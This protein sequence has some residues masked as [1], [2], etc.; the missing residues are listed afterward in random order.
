[1]ITKFKDI[2]VGAGLKFNKDIL[3]DAD[4]AKWKAM[5]DTSSQN[6]VWA[7]LLKSS[8]QYM[9]N[10][11]V[12]KFF[13]DP[14]ADFG[15]AYDYRAFIAKEGFGANPTYVAIYPNTAKDDNGDTLNAKNKYVLHFDKVPPVKDK[16]FWSVTAYND[17]NFLIDNKLDRYCINDRSGAVLN[18]DGSLDIYLQS[19]EPKDATKEKNWLPSGTAGF[20]IYMRVYLPESSMLDGTWPAPTLK[21]VTGNTS[22]DGGCD[23]GSGSLALFGL[24]ALAFPRKRR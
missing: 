20:H 6:S 19:D 17:D 14:I 2:G 13:G 23:M 22:A 12:F 21:K 1:M 5:T 8:Q 4:G 24:A 18:K 7:E 15:T 16:G 9:K 3:N 11:G 10:I